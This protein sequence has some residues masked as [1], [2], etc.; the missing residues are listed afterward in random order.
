MQQIT[1][2]A[3]LALHSSHRHTTRTLTMQ[4]GNLSKYLIHF[5]ITFCAVLA[6]IFLYKFLDKPASM[7]EKM[8]AQQIDAIRARRCC[9]NQG[10][11]RQ[12]S[13]LIS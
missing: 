7:T 2:T 12:F 10:T 9:S 13:D 6:A 4:T 5:A 3:V 8:D 11:I 1:T